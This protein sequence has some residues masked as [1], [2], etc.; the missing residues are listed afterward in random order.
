M[1]SLQDYRAIMKAALKKNPD[2]TDEQLK[3]V[4][5]SYYAKKGPS[6]ESQ[7]SESKGLGAT[8]GDLFLGRTK[9]WWGKEQQEIKEGGQKRAIGEALLSLL[10]PLGPVAFDP[11]T[12]GKGLPLVDLDPSGVGAAGELGSY[13]L[14][15][16]KLSQTSKLARIGQMG[17]HGAKVGAI[18]GATSP[19]D[20]TVGERLEETGKE[21][22]TGAAA[23]AAFQSGSELLKSF[24]S[25]AGQIW[26]GAERW[27]NKK[28]S[29]MTL[30]QP[31][32]EVRLTGDWQSHHANK[33]V[34]WLKNKIIKPGNRKEMADRL[35]KNIV[36][37][38]EE[39][40]PKMLGNRKIN[41]RIF[42]DEVDDLIVEAQEGLQPQYAEKLNEVKELFI[43]K[44]G[45]EM[46]EEGVYQMRKNLNKVLKMKDFTKAIEE[47]PAS[48]AVSRKVLLASRKWLAEGNDEFAKLLEDEA[49]ALTIFNLLK[50]GQ[51]K[52]LSGSSLGTFMYL[53]SS[54]P[55]KI[56]E[57]PQVL[58][59]V[60]KA[61]IP[62]VEGLRLP[63]LRQA[64]IPGYLSQREAMERYLNEYGE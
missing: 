8:L 14:P 50:F 43:E 55:T 49:A 63:D 39:K 56:L 16:G 17:L 1:P 51:K 37:P 38:A 4:V 59:K 41:A 22:L 34:G 48:V 47:N 53:I 42:V 35:I 27:I 7:S 62:A 20:L 25:K 32:E 64:I 9:D 46:S 40:I 23:G 12:S 19:E 44:Y 36:K 33:L 10:G 58:S 26:S 31:P 54:I 2:L 11:D 5:R 21:A 18:R 61:R 29:Q 3:Q 52:T 45:K 24:A 57:S 30:R 6:V 15:I 60:T 28:A 13:A